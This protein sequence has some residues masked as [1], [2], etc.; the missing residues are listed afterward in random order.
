MS[1]PAS[2]VPQPP[3]KPANPAPAGDAVENKVMS[4]WEHL[5]ELRSRLIRSVVVFFAI[6]CVC[7]LFN[8]EILLFLK[9][10][11]IDSLPSNMDAL[12]FTGPM[13]VFMVGMQV[14]GLASLVL[15]APFWLYQFW[16]FVEPALYPKER[17][18]ILPFVFCSAVMFLAGISFCFFFVLPMSLTFLINLGMKVG[19]PMITINDYI[20]LLLIMIFGFGLMFETP[21]VLVLLGAL[22]LISYKTLQQHRRI[23]F[24]I[25]LIVAAIFTP[26][27]AV[28][29]LS[30]AVPMYMMFE[31][32][33][34]IIR[35]LQTRK[36]PA[37]K[38][39]EK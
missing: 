9:Q 33:I 6:F 20:S 10:P 36:L 7:M 35:Y 23:I 39:S 4:L 37:E 29:M 30:M 38:K 24:L 1:D 28:S 19:T 17:K 13:D 22:D 8:E 18:Y 31:V 25:I 14:A 11:L 5:E 12:H 26:P 27:D 3:I 34:L 16:R 2:P 21:L 15:S 32:A